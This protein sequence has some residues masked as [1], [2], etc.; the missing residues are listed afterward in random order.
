[1]PIVEIDR[2]FGFPK[3]SFIKILYNLCYQ[4]SIFLHLM[5]YSA[6]FPSKLFNLLENFSIFNFSLCFLTKKT[7]QN[8][9]NLQFPKI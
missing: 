7:K 4:C 6:N 8:K 3:T 2:Y 1:M 5:L 9:L